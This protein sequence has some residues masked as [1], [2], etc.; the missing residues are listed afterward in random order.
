MRDS[1]LPRMPVVRELEVARVG[2]SSVLDRR[3]LAYLKDRT[4]FEV[5]ERSAEDLVLNLHAHILKGPEKETKRETTVT[6]D[7][8]HLLY[9]RYT[10]VARPASWWDHFKADV[11]SRLGW[12]G[13]WW[14]RRWPVEVRVAAHTVNEYMTETVHQTTNV[15][16]ET[17]TCRHVPVPKDARGYDHHLRFL[18]FDEDNPQPPPRPRPYCPVCHSPPDHPARQEGC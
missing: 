15:T 13:R 14:L 3:E 1:V 8:P 2:V 10:L 6:S 7:P 9:T 5:V 18:S 11:V 17:R 16:T 12:V 4:V